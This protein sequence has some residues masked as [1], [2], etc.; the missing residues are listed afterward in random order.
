MTEK[1]GS[2]AVWKKRQQFNRR[3]RGRG[4]RGRGRGGVHRESHVE[5]QER[6]YDD[7]GILA[8]DDE[9]GEDYGEWLML[10]PREVPQV[11]RRQR[12]NLPDA[13]MLMQ[14]ISRGFGS[15]TLEARKNGVLDLGKLAEILGRLDVEVLLEAEVGSS[16]NKEIDEDRS[17]VFCNRLIRNDTFV[18]YG[19]TAAA[20]EMEPPQGENLQEEK[21]QETTT[22]NVSIEEELDALLSIN[23]PDTSGSAVMSK[24][25][26]E[27][28]DAWFDSL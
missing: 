17:M 26:E 8:L 14:S 3:H 2:R 4:G 18:Q 19:D 1:A 10:C 11:M 16:W 28:L 5:S 13:E 27:D 15:D 7:G 21:R 20:T 24:G 23:A 22:N 6:V 25:E 12:R 9:N